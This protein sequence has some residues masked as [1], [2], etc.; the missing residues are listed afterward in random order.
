MVFT[1]NNSWLRNRKII[2]I[3]IY[4]TV[5]GICAPDIRPYIIFIE[6]YIIIPNDILTEQ[7]AGQ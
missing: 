7:T 5:L 4:V 3:K 1:T 6:M 2:N